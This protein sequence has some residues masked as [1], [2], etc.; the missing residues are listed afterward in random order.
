MQQWQFVNRDVNVEKVIFIDLGG[1]CMLF[2]F[3][4]W[5]LTLSAQLESPGEL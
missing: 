4:Q 3:K 5:F 2:D 1:T